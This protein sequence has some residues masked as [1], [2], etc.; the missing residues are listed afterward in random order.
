MEKQGES[1]GRKSI[2][3]PKEFQEGDDGP[4]DFTQAPGYDEEIVRHNLNQVLRPKTAVVR[5]PT[6]QKEII[7]YPEPNY[8]QINKQGLKKV[9]SNTKLIQYLQRNE[10]SLS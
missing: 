1:S 9:H 3:D 7:I 6:L 10:K 5:A 2:Y 4:Y 8:V